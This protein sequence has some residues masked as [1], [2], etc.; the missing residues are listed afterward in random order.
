MNEDGYTDVVVGAAHVGHEPSQVGLPSK[1]GTSTASRRHV[2]SFEGLVRISD[3]SRSTRSDPIRTL[4]RSVDADHEDRSR[5][6]VRGRHVPLGGAGVKDSLASSPAFTVLDPDTATGGGRIR[7]VP[8]HPA[9]R[10]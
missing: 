6:E 3:R 9:S 1:T 10:V 4:I 7:G 8:Q 2:V 5:S